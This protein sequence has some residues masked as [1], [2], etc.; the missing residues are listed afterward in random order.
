M[1]HRLNETIEHLILRSPGRAV[2]RRKFIGR[3]GNKSVEELC[4]EKRIEVLRFLNNEEL[5]ESNSRRWHYAKA[6]FGN[7]EIKKEIQFRDFVLRTK[8]FQFSSVIKGN[9]HSTNI[10]FLRGLD[11][12]TIG[13]PHA[14][15][16]SKHL[17]PERPGDYWHCPCFLFDFEHTVHSSCGKCC[18]KR[19]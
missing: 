2:S 12:K 8:N 1:P 9:H 18:D 13:D 17:T 5:L 14:K 4:R 11:K 7:K 3:I 6:F 19:H 10:H 15:L 16:F